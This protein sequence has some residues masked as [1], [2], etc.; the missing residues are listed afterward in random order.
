M[1]IDVRS[2]AKVAETMEAA[3]EELLRS[4]RAPAEAPSPAHTSGL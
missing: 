2:L 3:V 4:V 1:R